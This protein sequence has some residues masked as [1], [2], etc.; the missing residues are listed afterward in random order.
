MQ[1]HPASIALGFSGRD[2]SL[3]LALR[4]TKY[5]AS[6]ILP[7]L[8]R[9]KVVLKCFLRC[10]VGFAGSCKKPCD[11]CISEG[12]SFATGGQRRGN[13]A[14]NQMLLSAK[15]SQCWAVLCIRCTYV[16][17]TSKAAG[18]TPSLPACHALASLSLSETG[19]TP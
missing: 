12:V 15:L 8:L 17:F 1:Q 4:S 19:E 9:L 16:H 6:A 7:C 3:V 11:P 10:A 18:Q 2:W 5:S 13:V 14:L